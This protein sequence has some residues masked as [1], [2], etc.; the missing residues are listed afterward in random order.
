MFSRH[1][2]L[3][4]HWIAMLVFAL[5]ALPYHSVRSCCCADVTAA[6]S[7]GSANACACN[8]CCCESST[9]PLSDDDGVADAGC[10]TCQ[11]DCKCQK[12]IEQNKVVR[13]VEQSSADTP[14]LNWSRT[15]GVRSTS[16]SVLTVT[17]LDAAWLNSSYNQRRALSSVWLK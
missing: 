17:T 13:N 10:K 9:P 4:C 12:R 15:I 1:A 7:S 5:L 14:T 16:A 3:K 11:D 2:N 6:S 8:G